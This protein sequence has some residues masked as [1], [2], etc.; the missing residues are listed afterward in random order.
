MLCEGQGVLVQVRQG[1]AGG[2][3][4][5]V[6]GDIALVGVHL[7]LRPYR[8]A[9]ALSARLERTPAAARA[10]G[11]R[12]GTVPRRRGYPAPC[13]VDGE[14]C[15]A[16][17]RAGAVAG[18]V[19][20]DRGGGSRGDAARAH[21]RRGRPAAAPLPR[22]DRSG[23]ERIVVGDQALLVR[24][25]A[26][27]R[28]MAAGAGTRLVS[29][30]DPFEATRRG[31]AARAG[32]AARPAACRRRLADHRADRSVHG[33]RREWRRAPAARGQPRGGPRDCAPAAP[34]P[35]RRHGG[36]R[37]H[38]SADAGRARSCP[39]RPA[40]CA[41]GHD[42]APVQAFS[43]SRFGL[44]EISRKRTGPSLAELLGRPCPTCDGAGTAA[45]PALARGGA[46]AR[47]GRAAAGTADG[48]R[49]AGPARLSERGG[50][51]AWQAFARRHGDRVAL[52]V[53]Q[54]LA[55]GSHRIEEQAR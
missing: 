34:A 12:A 51:A 16:S 15:R 28:T 39:G 40:R 25:R 2:K 1:P 7:V 42:P 6:T 8:R 9:V 4:P 24:A 45:G 17:G 36:G 29:A 55:P 46:D 54:S 26:L 18:A 19:G 5:R 32:A 44:V 31:G 3:A 38:R 13:R 30:A 33:D 21:P 37:F 14:R 52:R 23:L 53:D 20:G 48:P 43:M 10:T 47:I 50:S 27:A 41:R 35:D 11:A 22:A 49:R